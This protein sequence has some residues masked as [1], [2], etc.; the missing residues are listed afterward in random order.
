MNIQKKLNN[1]P[2]KNW[3]LTHLNFASSNI[4]TNFAPEIA[5]ANRQYIRSGKATEELAFKT[6][7]N[8]F[9]YK[10][11]I[12]KIL[13]ATTGVPATYVKRLR[14]TFE[15]PADIRR[16]KCAARVRRANIEIIVWAMRNKNSL[17]PRHTRDERDDSTPKIAS[18]QPSKVSDY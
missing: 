13:S 8:I 16:S 14:R 12:V 11:P 15:C 4:F 7:I 3:T 6:A 17:K 18:F 10:C 1:R 2:R 5:F 9:R